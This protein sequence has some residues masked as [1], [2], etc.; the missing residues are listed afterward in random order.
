[1]NSRI[2]LPILVVCSCILLSSKLL[3]GPPPNDNCSSAAIITVPAGGFQYGTYTST[4]SDLTMATA[5]AGEFMQFAPNH[6]KSVWFQF[7][8]PTRRSAELE[9][10]IAAGSTI[11]NPN[12]AGVTVFLSPT[13]LPGSAN[14]LGA[15]ISSGDLTNPCLEPGTYLIQVTGSASVS[16]SI[17]VKL[18]LGCTDHP[19]DSK[20]DCPVEAYV[21]N[22]GLPLGASA[23]SDAHN[24]ECQSIEDPSE[25]NCLPLANKNLYL[26]STW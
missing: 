2:F 26:K 17:S 16:A 15:F 12:D 11:P 20:Y 10:I 7:T 14:K 5:E 6:T 1:M 13:C 21:F 4:V 23:I 9:I 18:T 22:S 3:Y 25:Y 8:I 19:V 24:I